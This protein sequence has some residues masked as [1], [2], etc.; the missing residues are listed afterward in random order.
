MK[1]PFVDL[2]REEA[3]KVVAELEAMSLEHHELRRKA[4]NTAREIDL[5]NCMLKFNGIDPVSLEG[6]EA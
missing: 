1:H 5:L 2:V 3:I 4:V 6:G